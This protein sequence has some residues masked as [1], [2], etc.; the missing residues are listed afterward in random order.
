VFTL[1]LW[2]PAAH[3]ARINARFLLAV[4]LSNAL[5]AALSSP[6]L[7]LQGAL[8][9]AGW[10]WLFIL[11]GA[12]TILLGLLAL[13]VLADGP[14]SVRWLNPREQHALAATLAAEAR[15]AG[16]QSI[17]AALSSPLVWL[18]AVAY[19]GVNMS[20]TALGMWLPQVVHGLGN[21]SAIG[22][23]LLSSAILLPGALAMVLWSRHSDVS[24]ER[25]RHVIIA[26]AVGGTGWLLSACAVGP[27]SA[28]GALALAAAGT[29][30]TLSVFWTLPVGIMTGRSGAAG[31]ALIGSV[32]GLGGFV[33]P[34]AIGLIRDV[35][36]DFT[37]AFVLMAAAMLVSAIIAWA[38]FTAANTTA[39]T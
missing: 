17:K 26:A 25:I 20:L 16:A 28:V 3:R 10:Q 11:E 9:L 7:A 5:A 24:G 22:A 2:F 15:T 33:G 21:F 18:L 8:G 23:G 39:P 32:G 12:P 30:M 27:A 19:F 4:P 31:I 1:G 14:S 37:G 35:T 38:A 13:F 34:W 6:I 36:G 29:Y